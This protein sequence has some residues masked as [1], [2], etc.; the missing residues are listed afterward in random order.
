M[1]IF[2]VGLVKERFIIS[3]IYSSFEE[4]PKQISTVCGFSNPW[5]NKRRA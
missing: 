1:N 3:V 4:K 2:S 5:L